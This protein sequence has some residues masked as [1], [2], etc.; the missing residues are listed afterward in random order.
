MKGRMSAGDLRVAHEALAEARRRRPHYWPPPSGL[1][2]VTR[3][4]RCVAGKKPG[5]G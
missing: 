1:S 4:V 2:F 3:P 5:N